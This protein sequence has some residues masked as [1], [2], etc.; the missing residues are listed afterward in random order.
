MFAKR[1]H[2][3]LFFFA[4]YA[5]LLLAST[6]C[7]W[8]VYEYFGFHSFASYY[9]YWAS[10]FLI[11]AARSVAIAELCRHV[12]RAYQGIWKLAWRALSV[13]ALLFLLHAAFDTW[14]QANQLAL[15]GLTLGRDL[16]MASVA[17]LAILLLI[18]NY[19]GLALDHAQK[20]IAFGILFL[21]S[22]RV[23]NNTILRNLFA[24]SLY[25][26]FLVNFI[27]IGPS[28]RAQVERA[29]NMWSM[30]DIYSL[31]ISTGIWCFA[32][33]KSLPEPAAKP[34]LLPTEVYREMSPAINVRLSAFNDRLVELLKP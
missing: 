8:I 10:T 22:V 26:S 23:I 25:S 20:N 17:I 9:A 2:R 18:R 14:G 13:L 19:Y 34:A 5:Y 6:A 11:L 12:L 33:R 30:I 27:S 31:L 4:T 1:L 16:D 28:M 3:S 24:G 32:L 21:C 29:T 15:Y 7:L